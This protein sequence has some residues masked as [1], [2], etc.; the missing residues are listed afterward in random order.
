[1][2]PFAARGCLR[3]AACDW[4]CWIRNDSFCMSPRCCDL[5]NI[6]IYRGEGLNCLIQPQYT[7]LD[8]RSE[9]RLCFITPIRQ[10][11]LRA[12]GTKAAS[13]EHKEEPNHTLK[14]SHEMCPPRGRV[15]KYWSGETYF[16][17]STCG[18]FSKCIIL[19]RAYFDECLCAQC[20]LD[21]CW[22]I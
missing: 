15:S 3:G 18:P 11:K 21:R 4:F 1:M 6:I 12:A 22:I 17:F 13:P 2:A 5:W 7:E 8:T 20:T 10:E 16:Y 9:H 14:I 19:C